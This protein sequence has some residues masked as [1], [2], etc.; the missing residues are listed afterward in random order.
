MEVLSVI[1]GILVEAESAEDVAAALHPFL[2]ALPEFA[3]EITALISELFAI[4]SCL[5]DLDS[6]IRSRRY[7]RRV[8][9]IDKDLDLVLPSLSTTLLDMLFIYSRFQVAARPSVAVYRRAWEEIRTIFRELQRVSLLARL[10][11]YRSFLVELSV[12]LSN[13]PP[14]FVDMPLLREKID[15]LRD[16]QD[17]NP[18]EAA[19]TAIVPKPRLSPLPPRQEF[20]LPQRPKPEA[21]RSQSYPQ[22][23]NYY[24]PNVPEVPLAPQV[25]QSPTSTFST[26][27]SSGTS[28]SSQSLKHW[29]VAIFDGRH[30]T[31]PFTTS[32]QRSR[33]IGDPT[34]DFELGLSRG[35]DQIVEMPFDRRSL[36][37]RIFH[38]PND[39]QAKILCITGLTKPDTKI[40]QS[41]LPLSKLRIF[42]AENT[43]QLCRSSGA[44]KRPVLWACLKFA[45]YERMV[46]FFCLFISMKAYAPP[47]SWAAPEDWILDGEIEE[48]G[49]KI[50]DDGYLHAL[51]I[52]QDIDSGGFRLQASV[53]SGSMGRAPVWTAFITQ[54]IGS[55]NWMTRVRGRC[56]QLKDLHPYIFTSS[57]Y[58]PTRGKRGEYELWF[59]TIDDAEQFEDVILGL[60]AK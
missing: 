49:G 26:T 28:G 43:L 10:E 14:G 13:S 30:S 53:M 29:A 20:N 42:R 9:M 60:R 47:G 1:D 59:Q 24:P 23:K 38:R 22:P 19:F 54:Y 58:K 12:R 46:L 25:P 31:T 17:N 40:T 4:S 5:R 39:N 48:Y 16:A 56:I 3:T 51:R 18:V 6:S 45:I 7:G 32:G 35:Y 41:C 36:T 34:G 37:V 21:F 52:F 27:S 44:S 50:E 57:D 33:C 2:S 55:Q 11:T 8:Y 15:R